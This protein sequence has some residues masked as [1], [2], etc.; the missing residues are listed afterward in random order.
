MDAED[1]R[2]PPRV[3]ESDALGAYGNTPVGSD[4]QRGSKTPNIRPP[5]ALRGWPE[6]R[7]FLLPSR[8]PRLLGGQ[9]DFAVSFVGI[10]MEAQCVHVRVG[11]LNIRDH[12]AGEIGWKPLLPE[13]VFA[14]NFAL[15]LRGWGVK[16]TNFIEAECRAELGQSVR[17]LGEEDGVIIDVELERPAVGQEG[18]GKEIQVGEKEFAF[19][20]F[21]AHEEAAAIVEHVE[22]R[23]VERAEWEPSVGG[24]VELPELADLRTLPATNW[25]QRLFG[26]CAVGMAILQCPVAYLSPVELEVVETQGLGS[27][28]AVGARW[29]TSQTFDKKLHDWF[30]PGG[31]VV[32]TRTA[33]RPR[34]RFAAS[35]GEQVSAE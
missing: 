6:H 33:R 9:F 5:R 28:E 12:L 32:T 7:T 13:L 24:G 14:F 22:H 11:L 23:E 29:R 10:A 34:V 19:I 1:N 20:E 31:G 18:G 35:A 27:D 15:R 26:R 8:V 30:R 2:C 3:F 17:G 25:S 21:G 4:F 16:E